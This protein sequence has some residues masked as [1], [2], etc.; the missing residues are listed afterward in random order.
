M[1]VANEISATLSPVNDGH[2]NFA[3]EPHSAA[4]QIAPRKLQ[5]S[6]A[7]VQADNP[8]ASETVS[9]V[10]VAPEAAMAWQV[11]IGGR[12]DENSVRFACLMP[13][14]VRST[15]SKYGRVFRMAACLLP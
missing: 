8:P 10:R 13:S 5:S 11:T 14:C 4:P 2:R 7:A 15:E 12:R 6:G 1:Y 3:A 9:T